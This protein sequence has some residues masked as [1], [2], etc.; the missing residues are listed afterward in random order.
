M[1][2]RLIT[3][4]VGIPIGVLILVLNNPHVLAVV[5]TILSVIA[6]FEVLSA[7]K[8]TKYRSITALSLVFSAILPI[9]FC[10]AVIR[11]YIVAVCFLFI[12][13]LCAFTLIRHKEIRFEE[14]GLTTLITICVPLAIS[15]LAFFAFR[16]P[17]H[18]IYF[19][20]YTLVITWVA[21]GGAYFA[22]TFLGKHKLCPG[23]S[24]KKTWEGFI[25]GVITAVVFAVLLGYGYELW[26]K[27]FTG[28]SHFS[29]NILILVICAVVCS[30]LGLVGDL[31][32][33]LLKRQCGVKD[34]G[35]L[36]PG[37][38]GVMDRFDSVLFTAPF[39][40]LVFQ[41]FNPITMLA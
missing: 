38:G 31:I 26:D 29:V 22:G 16:F 17:K 9:S 8:Y 40:Y 7:A 33:S 6:V 24:P 27:L 20:V 2:K 34:F 25:G 19:I 1:A 12:V 36:L 23:I 39:I 35:N 13:L 28:E 37:H 14:L 41:F 4:A 21:D 30:F 15:T 18:G 10:Y 3:A 5:T 32:A 11:Q